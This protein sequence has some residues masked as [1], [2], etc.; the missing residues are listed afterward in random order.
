MSFSCLGKISITT[1]LSISCIPR[2]PSTNSLKHIVL[3][4]Q[5]NLLIMSKHLHSTYPIFTYQVSNDAQSSGVSKMIMNANLCKRLEESQADMKPTIV[6]TSERDPP[7]RVK[8]EE[9]SMGKSNGLQ[10]Q[11]TIKDDEDTKKITADLKEYLKRAAG[12]SHIE[13]SLCTD[14]LI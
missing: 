11:P 5:K 8:V 7:A 1:V 10:A 14:L 13:S 6:N 9:R 12:N 2:Q 3:A 4:R